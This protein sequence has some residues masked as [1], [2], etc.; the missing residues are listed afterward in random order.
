MPFREQRPS[1]EFPDGTRPE[2]TIQ[3][4]S[5]NRLGAF[6]PQVLSTTIGDPLNFE[7]G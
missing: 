5:R 6:E 1:W 4:A 7:N 3:P 2:R